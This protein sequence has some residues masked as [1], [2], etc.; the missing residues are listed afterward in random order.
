MK[1]ND[2]VIARFTISRDV[3]KMNVDELIRLLK[4]ME[5]CRKDIDNNPCDYGT[6]KFRL[7]ETIK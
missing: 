1:K 6:V 7:L 5:Q 3:S 4:W 2:K